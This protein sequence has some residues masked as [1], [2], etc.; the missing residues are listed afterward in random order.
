MK[1]ETFIL[2]TKDGTRISAYRWI[3]E[4]VV[5]LRG[6]VQL[7]H[8]MVEHSERYN[9]FAQRLTNKG[10]IIYANDHRGHGKTAANDGELGHLNLKDGWSSI[11]NDVY[12]LS[13]LIKKE[14]PDIPL[15]LF[16]H[17]MGSFIARRIISDYGILFKGVILCG[18]GYNNNLTLNLGIAISRIQASLYGQK[19]RSEFINKLVFGA[20]NNRIANPKTGFDWLSR[21][22]EEVKKYIED[23]YCGEICTSGFYYNLFSGIKELQKIRNIQGIPKELP[24]F[25]ISGSDDPVGGYS[26]TVK[27]LY[28]LY[29][30]TGIK[31]ISI[32]IYNS[33]R[34]ELL[35]EINKDEI[36][37]DIVNWI[38]ERNK[39]EQS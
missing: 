5:E 12:E 11:L 15:L 28:N 19:H 31:D 33:C 27:K 23:K 21:D 22:E 29:K 39:P 36:I 16:G 14:N 24:L 7:V 4:K 6:A 38:E 34:H 9:N 1:K 26:A 3:P 13:Q 30:E 10:Y 37:N 35:N 2:Y 17:S 25:I 32:K 8:G 20:N 18:T